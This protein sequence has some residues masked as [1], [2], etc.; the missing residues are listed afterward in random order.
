M[1]PAPSQ[2]QYY[3][4]LWVASSAPDLAIGQQ[5][6]AVVWWRRIS[7][8]REIMAVDGGGMKY[9]PGGLNTMMCP[10]PPVA[11]DNE[12]WPIEVMTY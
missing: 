7:W 1:D 3:V 4:P 5:R 6:R 11:L 10:R 2:L 12:P 9:F 8:S